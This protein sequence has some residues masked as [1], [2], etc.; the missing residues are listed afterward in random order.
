LFFLNLSAGEFVTLLVALGG[1]ITA[2][3]LL[4][5]PKRK[6]V[7]STLRFWAAASSVEERQTRKRMREPWSLVLQLL[8]LL[9]LLLSIAEL[10]WGRRDRNGRDHVLLLDTSSWTAQ[11]TPEGTLL[12]NEERV[13][14]DYI[15]GLPARDRVMVV[16]V[17]GLATPVTSFTSDRGELVNALL[18]SSAGFS[19]LNIEQALSFARHAQSWSTGRPGE[20]V[21][22]GPQ[23]VADEET[24]AQKPA[25]LRVIAVESTREHC[26]IRRIGV[27]RNE[28]DANLW[29][30]VVTVK[31]YG[32]HRRTVHLR[33]QFAGTVFATRSARLDPG[34]ERGLE[35]NF[36]TTTAG[37]LI[38]EIE[39]RDILES[40]HRAVLELPRAGKLKVAVFTSRPDVLKPLLESNYRL[41]AKF[42]AP[43][44][45]VPKPAAD[46]M[47]LDQIAPEEPPKI[48]SLW[49]GLF[50][51]HSPLPIKAIVNDAA[52]KAW[53]SGTVLGAGL[54]ARG[55][56]IPATQVFETFDDD[57]PVASV[58]GGPIV[59]ARP[60]SQSH[61]K[62]SVIGYDPLD[63]Q[64]KFEASTPLLFANLL[65]WLS[66][67][68]IRVLDIS[69]APVGAAAVTLD[70]GER[71]SEEHL[72]ITDHN[73]AAVPFT[74][75]D[76]TIQL[77]VSRP[78]IVHITSDDR[79]RVL[80]LTL[81][82]IAGVE[83]EPPKDAA[84][85]LSSRAQ[86]TRG[87]MDLWK[88]LAVLGGIGSLAEWLLFGTPYILKRGKP[89]VTVR[90]FK[91]PERGRELVSK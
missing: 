60:A 82:D 39:P 8:S 4:D 51:E 76:Q 23:L 11:R 44:D 43:A 68:A 19:A 89:I 14:R 81:P 45:Y 33:T 32:S 15:A 65:R 6:K 46:V 75:R 5:R 74:V 35:Y 27:K 69:A 56:Q 88:W 77:F 36:T 3:Y 20:I 12:N 18:R 26:G 28:G 10:H 70:P 63:G 72:R 79:E 52:V 31:N 17:D 7:V 78:S 90:R 34:E 83:W 54:H 55:P 30:A 50:K 86:L 1:F 40:D 57:I 91:T 38:T 49:I 13:A 67:E 2:L 25:N 58:A 21:Y 84:S 85:G 62:F 22:I 9:F 87:A 61:P 80:S 37:Q 64:L 16:R 73:G 41:D 29:Q 71:I 47:L 53:Y 59:V 66:P 48:A 24:V 42:F